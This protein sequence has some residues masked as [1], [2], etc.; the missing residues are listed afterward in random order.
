MFVHSTEVMNC[1][2]SVF[3]KVTLIYSVCAVELVLLSTFIGMIVVFS[4]FNI[5]V[6][7]T[8]ACINECQF[9]AFKGLSTTFN[10]SMNVSLNKDLLTFVTIG[11]LPTVY[12]K[13]NY[14]N[15][16]IMRHTCYS[17]VKLTII[18]SLLT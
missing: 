15:I 1:Q 6:A 7:H 4:R 9:L 10:G 11:A 8:R 3:R 12:P 16:K 17:L 13:S 14:F 2:V 5:L 18:N